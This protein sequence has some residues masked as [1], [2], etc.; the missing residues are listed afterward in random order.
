[1][2]GNCQASRVVLLILTAL[3]LHNALMMTEQPSSSLFEFHPRRRMLEDVL[4]PHLHRLHLWMGSYGSGSPKATYLYSNHH[5]LAA[6]WRP[7]GR[8]APKTVQTVIESVSATGK[9]WVTGSADLK[10]TQS[11]PPDFG[12]AVANVV[13]NARVCTPIG[14]GVLVGKL[15]ELDL[16]SEEWADAHLTDA[17]RD[18]QAMQRQM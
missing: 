5:E 4:G 14:D 6:L 15:L 12:R 16:D 11:Y 18:L 10:G 1:M 13:V 2:A 17:C 3:L 7:L 8:Q 9:R